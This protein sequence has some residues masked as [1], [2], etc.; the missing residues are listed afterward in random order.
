VNKPKSPSKRW[1]PPSCKAAGG[2]KLLLIDVREPAEY[3]A[4]RIAGALLY[5][6]RLRCDHA[7]D[8][9][10]GGGISLWKREASFTAAEHRLAA[11]QDMP[12]TWRRNRCLEA[13]ACL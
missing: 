1:T 12:R 5:R 11:G 7:A 3:A 2:G 6:S 13:A 4:E 8:D 10:S 9:G